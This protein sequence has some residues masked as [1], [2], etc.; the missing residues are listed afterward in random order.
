MFSSYPEGSENSFRRSNSGCSWVSQTYQSKEPSQMLVVNPPPQTKNRN[1]S[2]RK[3][4]IAWSRG[5]WTLNLIRNGSF[6][7]LIILR[8]FM[9]NSS[10]FTIFV[11]MKFL[12]NLVPCY[13]DAFF[14]PNGCSSCFLIC[15]SQA[16][17]QL[18]YCLGAN[19]RSTPWALARGRY[20]SCESYGVLVSATPMMMTSTALLITE[21]RLLCQYLRTQKSSRL[22]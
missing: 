10:W 20:I 15:R 5:N 12:L 14:W 16:L 6:F 18:S 17:Q 7:F 22:S 2:N 8:Q 21:D 3:C 9:F 1:N 4:I 13:L 19:H 11:L